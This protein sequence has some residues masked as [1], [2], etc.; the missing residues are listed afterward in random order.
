MTRPGFSRQPVGLGN[1][2]QM[3]AITSVDAVAGRAYGL[4]RQ[5]A[6][7]QIDTKLHVGAVQA[8]P[9][10]GEQWMVQLTSGVQCWTL[11]HKMPTNSPASTI[12]QTAGQTQLGSSGP[13]QLHGS[14]IQANGPMQLQKVNAAT[15]PPASS[16][17]PG[18]MVY[19]TSLQEIL[20]ATVTGWCN[21]LGISVEPD[22]TATT[23]VTVTATAY[24][25]VSS[26]ETNT[27]SLPVAVA[28]H[29]VGYVSA[30]GQP[31]GPVASL[32]VEAIPTAV[33]AVQKA[34]PTTDLNNLINDILA[35]VGLSQTGKA[36]DV[37]TAFNDL[38]NNLFGEVN[39]QG[40]VQQKS[41]S[42]LQ[43]IWDNI[44]GISTPTSTS[45]LQQQA[46]GGLSDLWNTI[47]GTHTPTS[48][49][50][51]Q[52]SSM[53]GLT[54]FF[55]AIT[56]ESTVSSTSLVQQSGVNGLQEV[57]N[58]L[59]GGSSGTAPSSTSLV[60]Q[61]GIE[62][63]SHLWSVIFGSQATNSSNPLAQIEQAAITGLDNVWNFLTGG[64]GGAPPSSSSLLQAQA[65][66]GVTTT[67]TGPDATI[68][69]SITNAYNKAT[70]DFDNLTNDIL[71]ALGLSKTGN[72]ADV[73]NA[74]NTLL[75]DLFGSGAVVGTNTSNIQHAALPAT[76]SNINVDLQNLFND[77]TFQ[78]SRGWSNLTVDVQQLVTDLAGEGHTVTVNAPAQIPNTAINSTV[79]GGTS[80][81]QDVQSA[82][83]SA[84]SATDLA[85]SASDT[86]AQ[87]ASQVHQL[88]TN[89][90]AAPTGLVATGSIVTGITGVVPWLET[91]YYRVSA[92]NSA[93]VESAP[94]GEV[95]AF[96]WL[97]PLEVKLTWNA[98]TGASSYRV[99]RGTAA[100]NETQYATVTT[101]S[102]TDTGA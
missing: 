30:P 47:F 85:S 39:T 67:G 8:T 7:I 58:F 74:F 53:S 25:H 79:S 61:S 32:L 17:A 26:H 50:L 11:L 37:T 95:S 15:R 65:M 19:D 9:A 45:L 16:V 97:T 59:T 34:D 23:N 73:G 82:N 66:G 43:A 3:V 24:G 10:V 54:E 4:T 60:Q 98:V 33:G 77:I 21:L 93:A 55:N 63:L 22:V 89:A 83:G 96:A 72:A 68:G 48:T 12:P 80:L 88:L 92:I 86:A 101:N 90:P 51:V 52:Q 44:F 18:A 76:Y 71:A 102:F 1:G 100:G 27:T 81:G 87:A 35:G 94:S 69:D 49:S 84:S 75:G 57:W 78:D 62:G 29:A 64:T 5:G 70:T 41:I 40:Q 42:G 99:Y 6:N 28:A 14:A 46:I 13:L 38:L 36:G 31:V 91:A 56:G 2:I 20:V